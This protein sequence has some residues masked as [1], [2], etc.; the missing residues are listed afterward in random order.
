MSTP[1]PQPV[2]DA[3]MAPTSRIV[4]RVEMYESDGA[5]RWRP[6]DVI[7]LIDGSVDFDYTRAER[8][9]LSLTLDNSDGGIIQGIGELWYDKVIKVF[10][11]VEVREKGHV[12]KVLIAGVLADVA[13]PFRAS[14]V[15][16]GFDNVRINPLATT[17]PQLA[18]YDVI[19]GIGN[20][21][22]IPN[23]EMFQDAYDAGYCI[24]TQSVGV[25]GSDI[26][27]ITGYSAALDPDDWDIIPNTL[28]PSPLTYGWLAESYTGTDGGIPVSTATYAHKVSDVVIDST[29]GYTIV[30]AENPNGLGGKWVHTH[31]VPEYTLNYGQ[32]LKTALTWLN[33]G[34]PIDVWETQL[35]EFMIDKFSENN[36]PHAIALSGRDYTK[37]CENSEFTV[38]TT[39][40]NT[41]PIA[42]EDLVKDIGENAGLTKFNLATTGVLVGQTF[43]YD[44]GAPRW[45]AMT[46]IANAY[47]FDVYFDY[48][49][50]LRLEPY[51]DPATQTPV[52]T[53]Q[54][55]AA[56]NMASYSKST[57]DQR[58][59]NHVIVTGD[60][61]DSSVLPAFGEA[62]NTDP[63]SPTC[64]D[65]IGDRLYEYD[66][67]FIQTD[68]QANAVAESFLAVHALEEF[69]LDF[70]S[71]V[72]PW[73]EV[74]NVIRWLDPSPAPGDP[75]VFL[76]Q[77]MGVPLTLGPM[78]GTGAR[79]VART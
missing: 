43:S 40:D 73:V 8:G 56:G 62:I 49:G 60:S 15:N 25:S 5:T 28:E 20:A 19:V 29:A 79:V 38:S 67:S 1:P 78:S 61:S 63:N 75:D 77:T 48:W 36:F 66:S 26:P 72:F 16:V 47:N 41:T 18:G 12:P 37:K 55:G 50:Y 58:L 64:V 52:V 32:W 70:D 2:I 21:D 65:K 44:K 23:I 22:E 69:S 6:D 13:V 68:D 7:R 31:V 9:A 33:P 34:V 3:L 54:V 4:R 35:G 30:A 39:F 46:D 57:D 14:I 59:Y 24:F 74:G 11:G 76:L 51:A 42:L 45:T 53:L 17:V 10:W 71:I 27:F